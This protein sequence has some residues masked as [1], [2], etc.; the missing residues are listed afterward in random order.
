MGSS[1]KREEGKSQGYLLVIY[2]WEKPADTVYMLM[3]YKKSERKY[4]SK[5]QIKILRKIV[6]EWLQ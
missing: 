1:R 3:I 6:E 4:L 2:Y 5:D